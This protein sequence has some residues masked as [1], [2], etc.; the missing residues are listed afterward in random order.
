MGEAVPHLP[1]RPPVGR[2]RRQG[3]AP[4]RHAMAL[5]A[6][7][8]R[9]TRSCRPAALLRAPAQQ[10]V[11]A[12]SVSQKCAPWRSGRSCF[13]RSPRQLRRDA[14]APAGAVRHPGAQRAGRAWSAC[15]AWRPDRTAPGRNRTAAP[16]R[17]GS[18]PSRRR[19]AAVP[20]W[21]RAV[22]GSIANSRATTRSTLP[23][24]GT[25]GS[26]NA[27]APTARGGV[28]ADPG[29]SAQ[30]GQVARKPARRHHGPRAGVQVARARVVPKS[31]PGGEHLVQRRGGQRRR[32]GSAL[33]SFHSR[34]LPRRRWSAAA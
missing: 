9:A 25:A 8:C 27:I 22:A 1:G 6:S 16:W 5:R 4:P 18:A 7:R 19:R 28:G 33:R 17:P 29:Q 13:S 12:A 11:A 15:R 26:P 23:S 24:T 2:H 30:P 10:H 20:A 34:V 21:R 14:G 32:S 3:Q 31:C